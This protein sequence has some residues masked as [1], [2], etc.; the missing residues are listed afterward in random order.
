MG[1]DVPELRALE[2]TPGIGADSPRSTWTSGMVKPSHVEPPLLQWILCENEHARLPDAWELSTAANEVGSCFACG[3]AARLEPIPAEEQREVLSGNAVPG[4]HILRPLAWARGAGVYQARQAKTRR[5]VALKVSRLGPDA[6]QERASVRRE[7][8]ILRKLHHP[9]I[10]AFLEAGE[11]NGRAFF[12]MEWLAGPQLGERLR[13][14]PLAPRDAIR[15][16]VRLSDA[17]HHI[18]CRGFIYGELRPSNIVFSGRDVAKLVDFE[19]AMRRDRR[20]RAAPNG[21]DP[22]YVA[23]EQ[24]LGDNQKVGPAADVFGLGAIL[25]H[26]LTGELPFAGICS[27]ERIRRASTLPVP[28]VATRCPSLPPALD[29]I[30]RKCLDPQ[31]ENRY[32]QA[33]E[34]AADLRRI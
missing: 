8:A 4:H 14:G 24:W 15:M 5:L 17:I 9:G 1:Y 2:E 11:T 20:G 3:A 12:S 6:A 31:P 27:D 25:F 22:R 23:P 26:A 7:A 34:L 18:H 28:S 29:A 30:C 10:V 33:C 13:D 16:V 19:F 21:G 32:A